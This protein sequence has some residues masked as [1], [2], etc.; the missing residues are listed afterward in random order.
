VKH[1]LIPIS[2][3]L[4]GTAL[5]ATSV[6]AQGNGGTFFTPPGRSGGT[7]FNAPATNGFQQVPLHQA[8]GP[9]RFHGRSAHMPRRHRIYPYA[10]YGPYFYYPDYDYNDGSADEAPPPAA[11][12]TAQ[13][14]TPETLRA[15]DS[16]VMELRGDHWVRLT[17]TGPVEVMASVPSS[18]HPA[19]LPAFDLSPAAQPLRAAILVFCDGHQEEA[20]KYIIVGSIIFLK[21]DYYATGSWTRKV[22]IRDLDLPTTLKLNADRGTKFILPSRP[23]EIILRP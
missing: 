20:A 21:S 10:G 3:G 4:L 14:A 18:A 12:A 9:V 8:S 2:F 23:S 7:F 22:P 1:Q 19:V 5:L 13:P 15:A 11:R 6:S 16:I 17:T